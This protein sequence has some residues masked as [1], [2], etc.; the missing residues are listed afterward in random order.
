MPVRIQRR[1][2]K[3]FKLPS[4]CIYVGRPSKYGNPYTGWEGEAMNYCQ[5]CNNS[6][7]IV[8]HCGGDL[9]A[10]GLEWYECP[11]CDMQPEFT[12]DWQ[13]YNYAY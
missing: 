2:T 8:C 6:G 13:D 10:C 3:G 1:R 5:H 12:E 4:N 7:T 9:C 11:Y